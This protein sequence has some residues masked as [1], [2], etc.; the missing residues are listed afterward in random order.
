MALNK[1][2]AHAEHWKAQVEREK[3]RFAREGGGEQRGIG[4]S[5]HTAKVN[6]P[7][8]EIEHA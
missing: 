6:E 4:D 1:E 5:H 7:P 2:R 3:E 8:Y